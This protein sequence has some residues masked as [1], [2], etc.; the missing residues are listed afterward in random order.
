[1][2]K[3]ILI[4]IALAVCLVLAVALGLL[5]R[6][7]YN[8][9][10]HDGVTSAILTAQPFIVEYVEEPADYFTLYIDYGENYG[11]HEYTGFVG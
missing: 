9:G 5:C 11:I 6:V 10:K 1:M 3:P 2:R 8:A 7:S 4:I